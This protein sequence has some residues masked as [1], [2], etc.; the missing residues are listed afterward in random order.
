MATIL[1]TRA[2]LLRFLC[3]KFL[4]FCQFPY[5][6][7][8]QV[9]HLKYYLCLLTLKTGYTGRGERFGMYILEQSVF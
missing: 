7:L 5:G 9:S 4:V 1:H 8:G 3:L 2:I 6:I